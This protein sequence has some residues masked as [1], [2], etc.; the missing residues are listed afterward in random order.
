MKRL[1]L[2]FGGMI[3]IIS[4]SCGFFPT[5]QTSEKFTEGTQTS[6][7]EQIVQSIYQDE[8]IELKIP[9]GWSSNTST[10]EYFDLGL[11]KLISIQTSAPPTQYFTVASVRMTDGETLQIKFNQAYSKGPE[12]EEVEFIP[13]D[14]GTLT[15]IELKYQRPW[16]EPRW[17]FH[18][19]WV[20]IN[21]SIYVFSYRVYNASYDPQ[22]NIFE[23]LIAGVRIKGTEPV[24]RLTD[25]L[26]ATIFPK[27]P[28][29]ARITFSAVGWTVPRS[30]EEIFVMNVDGTGI[31][32]I[33]N[34]EGDDRDP[35]WSPDGKKIAFT[36]E[37][38]GNNEIYIMN[39]DGSN[40]TRLTFSPEN[41]HFPEWS[42]DGKLIV[43]SRTMTDNANDLFIVDLNGVEVARLTETLKVTESY[44]DWSPNGDKIVFSSFGGKQSGIWKMN[45]DGTNPHLLIAGPL[46]HPAWSPDGKYIAFDGEPGGNKFEV[47]IIKADGTEMRQITQHPGGSGEY[48]K[49]PSWS[50]DGYQLVYF[51]TNRSPNP[52][53]DIFIVN[54]DGSAEIQLT[55]GKNDLHHGGFYPS[56]SP[57]P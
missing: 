25:T 17:R 43:F 7:S 6:K 24:V 57:I 27:P 41:E 38:D 31:T 3:L 55:F 20:E 37:R 47:Y 53:T 10:G 48:N 40:Q 9:D 44:P 2:L 52:G 36:S 23:E 26:A 39:S 18:D 50:P 45:S 54:I 12:I 32:A 30:G 22:S 15:G 49:D 42:P 29:S 19:L 56:W 34:S 28:D 1:H 13:N 8:N 16:G 33:T 11:E 5:D 14:R 46:H 4:T 51:S 21:G 35:S